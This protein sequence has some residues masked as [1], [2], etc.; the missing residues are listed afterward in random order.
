MNPS[1]IRT[2]GTYN[3]IEW[4]GKKYY[5]PMLWLHLAELSA[6]LSARLITAEL[7]PQY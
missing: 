5:A 6:K 4:A 1:M 3:K 7:Y 2:A